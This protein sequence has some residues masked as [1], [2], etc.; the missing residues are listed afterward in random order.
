MSESL[1]LKEKLQELA[2]SI[3]YADQFDLT[4]APKLIRAAVQKIDSLEAEIVRWVSLNYWGPE[5]TCV[6]RPSNHFERL[7]A[8]RRLNKLGIKHTTRDS[9]KRLLRLLEKATEELV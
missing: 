7:T 2:Q 3:Q 1:T 6:R 5:Q 8:Q 9:T 4:S